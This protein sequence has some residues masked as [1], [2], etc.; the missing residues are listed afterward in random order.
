MMSAAESHRFH[1][2][3]LPED[4][5]AIEEAL[6]ATLHRTRSDAVRAALSVLLEAVEAKSHGW[7]VVFRKGEH[8]REVAVP[9]RGMGEEP[10]VGPDIRES[11][12]PRGSLDVRLFPEDMARIRQ[13]LALGAASRP[14]DAIRTALMLYATATR[15]S[16]GGWSFA[17]LSKSGEV[18]PISLPGLAQSAHCRQLHPETA[19]DESS[20]TDRLSDTDPKPQTDSSAAT[21]EHDAVVEEVRAVASRLVGL[22]AQLHDLGALL[23]ESRS[24][25]SRFERFVEQNLRPWDWAPERALREQLNAGPRDSLDWL[26]NF[27]LSFRWDSVLVAIKDLMDEDEFFPAVM[28]DMKYGTELF[29]VNVDPQA[30]EGLV[31]KL[32]ASLPEAIAIRVPTQ[33]SL[34]VVEQAFFDELAQFVLFDVADFKWQIGY[35]WEDL[36]KKWTEVSYNH[37]ASV[38]PK[39]VQE[40]ERVRGEFRRQEQLA[41]ELEP[42]D[43][44]EMG[45][46]VIN[47]AVA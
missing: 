2:N 42:A 47:S 39:L 28:H 7:R 34:I 15:R 19:D 17:R 31:R 25:V 3:L 20:A 37:M 30:L 33:L 9:Y 36:E 46:V 27:H 5:L 35:I 12:G 13:L 10:P 40:I 29:Y 1:M 44:L 8:Q 6:S 32:R 4:R 43:L 16:L 38:L 24:E 26:V 45:P 22:D 23:R 41:A 14:T 18:L 21:P 11:A